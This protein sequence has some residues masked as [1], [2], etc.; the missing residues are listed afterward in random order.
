MVEPS[1]GIRPDY[2]PAATE[3]GGDGPYGPVDSD[4][5]YAP[6]A[7]YADRVTD[8]RDEHNLPGQE[9]PGTGSHYDDVFDDGATE[10]QP[11]T[12][13]QRQL[14]LQQQQQQQQQ[15]RRQRHDDGEIVVE[16][17]DPDDV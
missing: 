8:L 9:L 16:D 4:D 3:D 12:R 15:R 2:N 5:R 13:R 17:G 7:D 14:H 1:F 11:M 10:P 6:P